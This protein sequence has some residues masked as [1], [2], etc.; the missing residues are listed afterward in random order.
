MASSAYC[1][2]KDIGEAMDESVLRH[3]TE[4]SLSATTI[5]A[6]DGAGAADS[7]TDSGNGLGIF[8][9]GNV[10]KVRGFA[11]AAN[12]GDQYMLSVAAGAIT[13]PTATLTTEAAGRAVSLTGS[14]Y[15]GSPTFSS[16]VVDLCIELA[17]GQ[18]DSWIAVR[19]PNPLA[20]FTTIPQ[21]LLATCVILVKYKL[22]TRGTEGV[23]ADV[24][25]E[26]DNAIAWLQAVSKGDADIGAIDGA[27]L[28]PEGVQVK[29]STSGNVG[30]PM[31]IPKSTD[32]VKPSRRSGL[33]DSRNTGSGGW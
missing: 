14:D 17:S 6:V 4:R 27:E 18:I 31:N 5:A 28:I 2:V 32:Y 23:P 21:S 9:V 30:G 1:I 15:V 11:T 24:Q 16:A 29:S 13:V 20:T 8:G 19:Y 7:F 26:Y 3:L 22:Y 12:N 33:L 25:S 10:L